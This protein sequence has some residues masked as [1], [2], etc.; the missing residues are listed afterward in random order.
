MNL[1]K[2]EF[3]KFNSSSTTKPVNFWQSG[4]HSG[5]KGSRS[6]SGPHLSSSDPNLPQSGGQLSLNGFSEHGHLGSLPAY[7]VQFD[8]HLGWN[9]VSWQFGGHLA[10][11]SIA[12]VVSQ[13]GGQLGCC[14]L[15]EHGHR[16]SL[17]VNV[18][19]SGGHF[20]CNGILLQLIG[21]LGSIPL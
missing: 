20:G 19:H 18:S 7:A 8:G 2:G 9:G 11:F 15:A 13:T 10:S 21:H 3:H 6:Q 16:S 5:C 4:G 17:P 1:L 14:G 12:L